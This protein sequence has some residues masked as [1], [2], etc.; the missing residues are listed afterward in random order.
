MRLPEAPVG[1]IRSA[2]V[3]WILEQAARINHR[4]R[5]LV[6]R[7]GHIQGSRA[8]NTLVVGIAVLGFAQH[9]VTTQEESIRVR[10]RKKSFQH[11]RITLGISARSRRADR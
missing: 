4:Q 8:Q 6:N 10:G 9:S 5:W 11:I 2:K 1:G 3:S 7:V